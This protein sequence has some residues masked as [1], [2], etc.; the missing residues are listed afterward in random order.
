[1]ARQLRTL[2]D[3]AGYIT[4]LPKAEHDAPEW[5]TTIETLMLVAEHGRAWPL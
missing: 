2:R 3:A 5:R 4:K 1:M